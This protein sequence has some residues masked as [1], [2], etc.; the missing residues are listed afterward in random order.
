MT[1]YNHCS[2]VAADASLG[3]AFKLMRLIM[4]PLVSIA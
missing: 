2:Y 4:I 1:F 3:I